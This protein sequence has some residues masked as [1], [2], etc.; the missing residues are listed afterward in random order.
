MAILLSHG[1]T[2]FQKKLLNSIK[3][4]LL[5]MLDINDNDIKTDL[6]I[7]YVLFGITGYLTTLY[8]SD[9][10]INNQDAVQTLQK[11]MITSIAQLPDINLPI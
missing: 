9:Q 10:S 5:E 3:P 11:L 2:G 7:S 4:F 6:I 8:N 1:D